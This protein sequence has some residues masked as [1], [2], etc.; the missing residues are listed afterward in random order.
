MLVLSD[1]F[2]FVEGWDTPT[3]SHNSS[4]PTILLIVNK[5][6]YAGIRDRLKRFEEDLFLEG[7]RTIEVNVTEQT[8][9]P[10]IRNILKSYY[11]NTSLIGAILIGNIKAAYCK[12][13]TGDYSN[14]SALNIWISLDAMDHYYMDLDGYWEHDSNPVFCNDP[15]KPANVVECHEYG[16]CEIFRNEY[17]VTWGRQVEWD[18]S[19]VVDKQQYKVEIWVA[20]IMGHN[21]LIP[22][23]NESQIINDFFDW[24][25]RYRRSKN[26]LPDR[27]YILNADEGYND[28]GMNYSAFIRETVRREK[29]SKA[30]FLSCLGNGSKVLYL[31]SHS[32][33]QGHLLSDGF[34]TIDDLMNNEKSS[35]FYIL[36]ACSSCRW[37][38]YVISPRSPNYLGGLYVFAKTHAGDHGLAAMGFTGVGGFN[39]LKYLTDYINTATGEPIYGEA[40]KHWLNRLLDLIFGPWNFVFLGDPTISPFTYVPACARVLLKPGY[41]LISLP[42]HNTSLTA[43]KLLEMIGDSAQS[44]FMFNSSSQ[45]YVSYDINLARFGIN[46]TDFKIVPDTGYF[47]YVSNET[48]IDFQG[49]LKY[50]LKH[51]FITTN[52]NLLGWSSSQEV[53]ASKLI[54]LGNGNIRSIFWFNS[55]SQKW[56]SY[57]LD[58]QK[59]GIEQEDFPIEPGMGIFI[60]ARGETIVIYDEEGGG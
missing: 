27:V 54:T 24:D 18:Y 33:P 46:Q 48:E 29:V 40:Y 57:D 1:V 5:G 39:F 41:N 49:F 56:I 10:T 11:S 19:K 43:S 21:L 20:R 53:N 6:I 13:R 14:P 9:P 38:Q 32:W 55:T 47:I 28:Q 17:I 42:V 26:L 31:T 7:Y 52:Y 12:I 37:D 16:S 15:Y 59:F 4:A 34:V 30:E 36:N 44:I 3:H 8:S 50:G 35:V 58:L 2:L 25:H 22:G 23:K 45:R 51:F 60:F